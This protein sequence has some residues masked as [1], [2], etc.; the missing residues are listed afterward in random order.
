MSNSI[1]P[2]KEFRLELSDLTHTGHDLV[3]PESVLALP[4]G[5]LWTSDGRGG[6]TR[7]APDGQQQFIGGLG[8]N[9]PNGL[10]MADDGSLIVANLGMSKVQKL[11]PDGQVDD[12]LTEVD[13]VSITTPNFVFLDSR[14]RLWISVMTREHHWW[15]AAASP[16]PDG[17]IV[18]V[19]EKGPRI[20]ADGLYLTNEIR[21][22]AAEEYLYV[23]ET[24]MNHI[25]RFRVQPDGS[26]TD[27]EIFGPENLGMGAAIDGFTFDAEGNLWVTLVLRNGLGIITTDGD[28]HVVLEDPREDVLK[29]FEEK[30]A[31]GTAEPSDMMMAAGP[32]LQFITSLAFGGPDL[33][34]AYLGSL[35]MNT[36]PT[37]QSPVAGL[38]LRHWK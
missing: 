11:H 8:G 1:V 12:M 17:Y 5:T 4:D 3:R 25:L 22:D 19:D 6:V 32:T 23:V 36:L 15:P 26:L 14:K 21:L 35:A 30:I 10:A 13:G 27:K 24:M 2:I 37:F 20:V 29:S 34:T 31:G 38:P 16:R 9:E 28:Y 7:I 33:R 18:L